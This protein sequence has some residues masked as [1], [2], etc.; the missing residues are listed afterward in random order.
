MLFVA[1]W[2]MKIGN[3]LQFEMANG[4]DKRSGK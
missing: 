4:R 1:T 2:K 3:M